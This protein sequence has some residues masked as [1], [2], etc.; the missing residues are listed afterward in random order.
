[1]LVTKAFGSL[2]VVSVVALAGCLYAWPKPGE[3]TAITAAVFAV[4]L[5]NVL[6][7]ALAAIWG[8]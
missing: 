3:K 6:V 7:T 8:M 1:V 2:T 4:T 5:E